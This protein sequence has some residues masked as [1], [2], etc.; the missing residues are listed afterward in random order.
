MGGLAG[1]CALVCKG[2]PVFELCV[3]EPPSRM[4]CTG[5]DTVCVRGAPCQQC[6]DRRSTPWPVGR[7]RLAAVATVAAL[8]HNSDRKLER[9]G[10]AWASSS[11]GAGW[12]TNSLGLPMDL[13]HIPEGGWSHT[14]SSSGASIAVVGT[15]LGSLLPLRLVIAGGGGVSGLFTGLL[16]GLLASRWSTTFGSISLQEPTQTNHEMLRARSIVSLHTMYV[17]CH[18]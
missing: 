4:P 7:R 9:T 3:C 11:P 15:Q 14:S 6:P 13:L 17:A 5:T 1:A 18:D 10:E 2:M 8:A 16:A 12:S